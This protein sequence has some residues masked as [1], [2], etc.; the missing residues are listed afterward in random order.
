MSG[1]SADGID[2]AVLI[3]DGVRVTHT[4]S[5]GH[6]AYRQDTREAIRACCS[7]PAMFLADATTRTNL[8]T[9]IAVDH[10]AAVEALG[11]GP[12]GTHQ[13][14]DRSDGVQGNRRG[15]QSQHVWRIGWPL[16]H[17]PLHAT[18]RGRC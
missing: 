4:A 12:E 9:A 2:A 1:T 13:L 17:G 6:F 7:D 5:C 11:E 15:G 14:R 8:D 10:T 3:T 16:H 18:D